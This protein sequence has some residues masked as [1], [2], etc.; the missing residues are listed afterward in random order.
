MWVCC[1]FRLIYSG[2]S[3][4]GSHA[5]PDSLT[6]SIC[7]ILTTMRCSFWDLSLKWV[8]WPE[9]DLNHDL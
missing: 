5:D 6:A 4:I 7:C 2:N 9:Q 8:L 1:F 3:Q